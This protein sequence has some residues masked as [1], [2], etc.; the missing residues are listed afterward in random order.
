MKRGISGATSVKVQRGFEPGAG[1]I[2]SVTSTGCEKNVGVVASSL[3]HALAGREVPLS[4][5]VD[6]AVRMDA[7]H[8]EIEA[9]LRR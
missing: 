2:G 9:A 5:S 1:P 3:S 7:E 4:R 8:V 6:H